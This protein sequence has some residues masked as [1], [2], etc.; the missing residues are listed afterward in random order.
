[1]R[2]CPECRFLGNRYSAHVPYAAQSR[3]AIAVTAGNNDCD[4]VP[5]MSSRRN[6]ANRD[7]VRPPAMLRH[8][9]QLK[10]SITDMQVAL[11]GDHE[12]PVGRDGQ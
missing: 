8:R 4:Q 9:L 7:R 1:M 2:Q 3:R 12:D 5:P 6:E 10:R 11:L